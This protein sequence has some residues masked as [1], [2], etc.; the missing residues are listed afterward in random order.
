MSDPLTLPTELL[1][2]ILTYL[3]PNSGSNLQ[4]CALSFRA[5]L[6]LAQKRLFKAIR[7]SSAFTSLYAARETACAKLAKVLEES[8]HLAGYAQSLEIADRAPFSSENN[9]P[10]DPSLTRLL[11]LLP[12]LTHLSYEGSYH[13]HRPFPFVSNAAHVVLPSL[14][15]LRLS[16]VQ[17]LPLWFIDCFPNLRSLSMCSVTFA[18]P[19]TVTRNNVNSVPHLEELAVDWMCGMGEVA[20]CLENRLL[21]GIAKLRKLSILIPSN[22]E[23]ELGHVYGIF[24]LASDSGG[25]EEL[26]LR[27]YYDVT[28]QTS[29]PPAIVT[30]LLT[31]PALRKLYFSIDIDADG[32]NQLPWVI[33]LLSSLVSSPP[34]KTLESITLTV[35]HHLAIFA[36]AYWRDLDALFSSPTSHFSSVREVVVRMVIPFPEVSAGVAMVSNVA[37]KVR[38]CL[39]V[40]E[41]MGI[42]RAQLIM[43]G[44][45]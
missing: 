6:P 32:R 40:L 20:L 29:F 41:G 16:R 34:S 22:N 9:L 27:A 1:D 18:Y 26:Q 4:A 13:H 23:T 17:S 2:D 36:R 19:L 45:V 37:G 12:S 5:F 14:T 3:P 28:S 33:S 35:T 42:L 8:S 44:D 24:Q 11:A 15:H 25:L 30:T 39:P 43:E 10:P 38:S 7:I 31:L 21:P